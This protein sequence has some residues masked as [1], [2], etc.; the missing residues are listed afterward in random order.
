LETQS[1]VSFLSA[2]LYNSYTKWDGKLQQFQELKKKEEKF[3]KAE[4]KQRMS[5]GST[6]G[7]NS[8]L[9]LAG[10]GTE[11][12][13]SGA[14]SGGTDKTA[15]TSGSA[16][17]TE[18]GMSTKSRIW[19]SMITSGTNENLLSSPFRPTVHPSLVLP[20]RAVLV[21]EA[22]PSSIVAFALARCKLL[23]KEK[24]NFF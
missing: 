17:G 4:A 8:V 21:D 13:A 20:G 12:S 24:L 11:R 9:N 7:N 18:D 10:I 6:G 14:I 16:S 19:Q 22:Q 2:S 1:T 23:R 15:A 5:S 3:G